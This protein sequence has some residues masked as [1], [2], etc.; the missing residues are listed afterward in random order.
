MDGQRPQVNACSCTKTVGQ[1]ASLQPWTGLHGNHAA[2][3]GQLSG[4]PEC[5]PSPHGPV[6]AT[7]IGRLP[8]RAPALVH[9]PQGSQGS[10]QPHGGGMPR[11]PQE[12]CTSPPSRT[13]PN[14]SSCMCPT[15]RAGRSC[16]TTLYVLNLVRLLFEEGLSRQRLEE[17]VLPR[18][19][20]GCVGHPLH[21]PPVANNLSIVLNKD[22]GQRPLGEIREDDPP[23]VPSCASSVASTASARPSPP[24]PPTGRL[25]PP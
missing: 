4:A 21:S 19:E 13:A 23:K 7:H 17:S 8:P 9:T 22:I 10:G 16:G 15:T 6:C 14:P 24:T 5:N 25:C 3:K 20:F 2:S 18:L 1:H 11:T 12:G